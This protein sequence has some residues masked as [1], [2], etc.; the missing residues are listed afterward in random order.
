[1]KSCVSTIAGSL[2][3]VLSTSG[4]VALT[5]CGGSQAARKPT[6]TV[7]TPQAADAEREAREREEG[8]RRA[9]EEAERVAREAE[10]RAMAEARARE[11]RTFE[12]VY[13]DYDRYNI[14]DDQKSA[15]ASH[16]EKLNANRE[17]DVVLEGHCDERGTIEYNLALGQ[18]RAENVRLFLVRSGV[19]ARKL[20][21]V[22]YGKERPADPGHDESA[23]AKNRRVEFKVTEP[24]LP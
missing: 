14:R 17:F 24:G 8:E 2:A 16:A 19:D 12:N 9:R 22:S 21:T 6:P 5:G 20:T 7:E 3:L 18:K 13:F 1:M 23:W 10:D 15:L 4:M 11:A